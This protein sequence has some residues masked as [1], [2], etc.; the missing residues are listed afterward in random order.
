MVKIMNNFGELLKKDSQI[1]HEYEDEALVSS[2]R[3]TSMS[4]SLKE[5]Q[6]SSEFKNKNQWLF[7]EDDEAQSFVFKDINEVEVPEVKEEEVQEEPVQE[8]PVQE[9]S[10]QEEAV[11]E[12][13]V[14]EEAAQKLVPGE[15]S[16]A[17]QRKEGRPEYQEP[18]RGQEHPDFF[19]PRD[20]QCQRAGPFRQLQ[21]RCRRQFL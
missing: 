13:S 5:E 21:K 16:S 3:C 18:S 2:L 7:N 9:E 19:R 10:I 15:C 17:G 14:Q 12:E 8:E 6:N 1:S 20:R 4:Y 11:Q